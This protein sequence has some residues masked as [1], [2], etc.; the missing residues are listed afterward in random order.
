VPPVGASNTLSQLQQ[1]YKNSKAW[2]RAYKQ[3]PSSACARSGI[4]SL[5]AAQTTSA[6][7]AYAQLMLATSPQAYSSTNKI[8]LR[9]VAPAQDQAECQTCTAFAV[10]AAAE[11]AM[12]AALQVDVQQCSI[13]VQALFFC[14]PNEPSRSCD[15]GWSLRD[16]LQQLQQRGQSLPTASCLPYKPDLFGDQTAEALCK[17][18][19]NNPSAYAGR[20]RFSSQSITSVWKAQQHIR[21]YG[22]VVSR[23]DVSAALN[24]IKHHDAC[25]HSRWS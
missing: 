7:D 20:G 13:S 25:W 8:K 5:C 4:G 22:G 2:K 16:A 23:F 21:Q 12:A 15:A 18:P 17:G 10:A 14:G 19:C 1:Q 11:T 6:T 3:Q 24:M 9:L